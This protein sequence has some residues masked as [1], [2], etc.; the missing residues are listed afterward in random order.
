[1]AENKV[2]DDK[3]LYCIN[4]GNG[5]VLG[6]LCNPK[7]ENIEKLLSKFGLTAT[8]LPFLNNVKRR[9]IGNEC[10]KKDFINEMEKM[11]CSN[12]KEL[13]KLNK[14]KEDLESKV[15]QMCNHTCC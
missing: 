11:S 4:S 14:I 1:M 15:N 9:V 6:I 7:C 12:C 10:S 2:Y 3:K 13:T 8:Y 5:L